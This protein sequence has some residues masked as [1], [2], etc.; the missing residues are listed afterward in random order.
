MTW[1]ICERIGLRDLV[2]FSMAATRRSHCHWDDMAGWN[3]GYKA[4]AENEIGKKVPKS[5]KGP[6]GS[7]VSSLVG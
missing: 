6:T 2:E 3:P 7:V 4:G 5:A 1:V